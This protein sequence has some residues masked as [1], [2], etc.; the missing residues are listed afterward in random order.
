M[1]FLGIAPI[2]PYAYLVGKVSVLACWSALAVRSFLPGI[3]WF[4]SPGLNVLGAVLLAIGLLL[5]V[6]G[7]ANL[8]SSLRMGLPI[9]KTA[10]RTRGIYRHTRNPMYVGGLLTCLAAVTWTANPVIGMLSAV[11]AIVH[12][13]IVLMEEKYLA[14]EFGNAWTEYSNKVHRYL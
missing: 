4:R 1:R 5:M 2:N 9:E 3:V 6:A 14:A 13:R 12:H 10:L 11:A 8:G 7:A